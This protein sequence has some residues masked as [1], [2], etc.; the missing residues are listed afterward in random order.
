MWYLVGWSQV[1]I[2][3][4]G[5][6]FDLRSIVL[7]QLSQGS[8]IPPGDQANGDSLAAKPATPTDPV[9]GHNNKKLA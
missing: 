3:V 2:D 8:V 4:D 5:H 7:L 6:L 1:V 9:F